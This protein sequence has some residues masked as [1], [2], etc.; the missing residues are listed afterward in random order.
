MRI[1]TPAVIWSHDTSVVMSSIVLG[2]GPLLWLAR[3]TRGWSFQSP[4]DQMCPSAS[5]G[6][7]MS[8]SSRDLKG[9]WRGGEY[10]WVGFDMMM[11][12]CLLCTDHSD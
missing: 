8:N 9:R 11:S 3:K 6:G 5:P 4:D 12:P 1:S 2:R 7:H 10:G